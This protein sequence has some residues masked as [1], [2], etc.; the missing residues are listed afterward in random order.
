MNINSLNGAVMA[1]SVY[2]DGVQVG[3]NCEI[4]LPE[5]AFATSEANG[6]AGTVELPVYTK[7]DAMECSISTSGIG[8]GWLKT[9]ELKPADLIVN[10]VQQSVSPD[11]TQTPQHFKAFLRVAPKG[12]PALEASYGE[13]METER[14]FSVFSY[15]LDVNGKTMLKIDPIKGVVTANGTNYAEKVSKML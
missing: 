14:T 2:L 11:G 6:A 3:W 10:I 4:K 5:V 8:A 7:T 9:L 12:I 15:R 1:D 13:S